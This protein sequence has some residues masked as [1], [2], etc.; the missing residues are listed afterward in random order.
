MLLAAVGTVTG[1]LAWTA[2]DRTA[3]LAV[4]EREVTAALEEAVA[5]R[6]HKKWSE[7][8]EGAKRAQGLLAED[9]REE[10]RQRVQEVLKDL[11]M[12]LAV[13]EL[14]L[15]RAVGGAE[16]A[17]DH[18]ATDAT[19]A[20]EFRDYGIDVESLE[21][22]DAAER[23][24]GQT[25]R[26][27]LTVALDHWASIRSKIPTG[28]GKPDDTRWKR[29][30]AVARAADPDEWRNQ[31]RDA[32][33]L[34]DVRAL[35]KLAASPR[36]GELPLQTLSLLAEHLGAKEG[37]AVLRQAQAKYP[38]DFWINFQLAWDLGHQDPPRWTRQFVSTP[39]RGASASECPCTQVPGQQTPRTRQDGRGH[40]GVFEGRR[41]GPRRR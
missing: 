32:L 3:R 41:V 35:N 10:L 7:A 30:V 31:V 34:R 1:S 23:I 25:I 15:P 18:S 4:T 27:E 19:Y 8:L 40:R 20:K 17:I 28:T 6:D 13:E 9:S 14:R 16:G 12:V 24:R 29:L 37:E 22:A 26:L 38:D 5:L 11:K 2:R 33:E 21:S 36:I 39:W